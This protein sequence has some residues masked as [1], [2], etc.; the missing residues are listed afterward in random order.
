MGLKEE[1]EEAKQLIFKNL[2]FDKNFFVQNFEITIRLLGGLISAYQLDGDE[3][4]LDLAEDLG[5]RLLP[6]Q[7]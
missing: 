4:F 6:V 7:F 5:N 3:R 2:S 1:S